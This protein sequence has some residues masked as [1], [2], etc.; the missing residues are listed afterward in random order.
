MTDYKL[1]SKEL[2]DVLFQLRAAIDTDTLNL[3]DMTRA[4]AVLQLYEDI[5]IQEQTFNKNCYD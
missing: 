2:Y 3:L 4:D 5:D 1:I